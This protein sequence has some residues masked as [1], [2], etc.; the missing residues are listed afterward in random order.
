PERDEL[1]RTLDKKGDA[2]VAEGMLL[3]REA[4]VN[5][6]NDVSPSMRL[7]SRLGY[8]VPGRRHP[9][10]VDSIQLNR[11]LERVLKTPGADLRHLDFGT[12]TRFWLDDEGGK[13][14][15]RAIVD[16]QDLSGR[17]PSYSNFHNAKIKRSDLSNANLEGVD[18]TDAIVERANL[19]GVDLTKV[20][21]LR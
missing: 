3:R 4:E 21:S 10:T 15:F 5:V 9:D 7:A 8:Y 14:L 6:T 11:T 2:V 20:K 12:N 17:D 16:E 1:K 13:D 18:L 19:A